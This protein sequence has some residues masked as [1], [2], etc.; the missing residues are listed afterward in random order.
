MENKRN[1]RLNYMLFF[2]P[3]VHPTMSVISKLERRKGF[4]RGPSRR[5]G[6]RR[7]QPQQGGA[8]PSR[9]GG[10]GR[11]EGAQ[12]PQGEKNGAT[13]P[14]MGG[15]NNDCRQTN[16]RTVYIITHIIFYDGPVKKWH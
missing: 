2:L 11:V 8:A 4:R 16:A 12:R 7:R 6:R 15:K 10:G 1:V 9:A 13:P 14:P 3:Q 5:R